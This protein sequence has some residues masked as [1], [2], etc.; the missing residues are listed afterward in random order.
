MS[1]QI[2]P[3]EAADYPEWQRLW[4]IYLEYYETVLDDA[5]SAAT[6]ERLLSAEHP[7]INGLIALEE[8]RPAGMVHYIFHAS[9]WTL[10]DVCYLED[11]VVE[12]AMR[13]KSIGR[14]LIEGVYAAAD[15][16][17]CPEVYWMTQHFNEVG[18]RLYDRVGEL[19]P[20]LR[21]DRP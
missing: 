13:G 5:V 7:H 6:W 19:T 3:L 2:R 11:L 12:P 18:R 1:V 15:E 21:Y 9:T 20:F 17:G 4:A 14:A 8:G 16:A 10:E